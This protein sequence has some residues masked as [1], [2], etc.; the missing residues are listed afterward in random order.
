MHLLT[1]SMT[2]QRMCDE[3]ITAGQ[4]LS[5]STGGELSDNRNV[6]VKQRFAT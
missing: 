4:V 1:M 6:A 5:S 3:L 2:S